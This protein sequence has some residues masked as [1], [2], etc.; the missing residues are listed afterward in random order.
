MVCLYQYI[1]LYQWYVYNAVTIGADITVTNDSDG[2][3]IR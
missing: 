3:K 1:S 2:G